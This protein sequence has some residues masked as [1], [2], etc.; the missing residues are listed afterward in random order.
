MEGVT[1]LEAKGVG[2][3]GQ[4]HSNSVLVR[5]GR[6]QGVLAGCPCSATAEVHRCRLASHGTYK[7]LGDAN[8]HLK[9]ADSDNGAPRE[10]P[11]VE[12]R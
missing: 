7:R 9:P 12:L 2:R 8:S 11:I 6:R 1:A 10:T 3:L 5:A 4:L